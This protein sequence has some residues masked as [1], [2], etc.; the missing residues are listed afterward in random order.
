MFLI[1]FL[2][3][4]LFYAYDENIAYKSAYLSQLN[5]CEI[6]DCNDCIIDFIVINAGSQALQGFDNTTN[7]IFTSFRGSSNMH[8]WIEN[9]Q[10]THINPY[11]N[12]SLAVEKG[13]YKD[14]EYIKK[15]LFE[16]LDD[17]VSLYNTR[18]LLIT[19]H[20]LGGAASTLFA[21]DIAME[22]DYNILHFYNFGSPRVGNLAFC[23]IFDFM[24][25]GFRVVHNN[26]IVP[27]LPPKLFHYSHIKQGIC[28]NENNSNYSYC[29]DESCGTKCS[30]DDH[31]HYLNI[32]MGSSGC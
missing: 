27:S 28:Y 17:L 7:T 19:G 14:Y 3:F 18:D 24:I 20:S 12:T 4:Q 22:K 21:F 2:L 6:K 26:D 10:V 15:Q 5:Y 29:D 9:I 31:I 16:N 11:E 25:D 30:S 23:E 13:F 1:V 8:N 32:T